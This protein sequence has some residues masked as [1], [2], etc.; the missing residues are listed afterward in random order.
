MDEAAKDEV[1]DKAAL[2]TTAYRGGIRRDFQRLMTLIESTA[3]V[4]LK[5]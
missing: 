5:C 2:P 1:Y 3:A 4:L